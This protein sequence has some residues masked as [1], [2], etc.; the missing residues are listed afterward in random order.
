MVNVQ[1]CLYGKCTTAAKN[2]PYAYIPKLNPY[3][4]RG[5]AY[6]FQTSIVCVPCNDWDAQKACHLEEVL[7]CSRRPAELTRAQDKVDQ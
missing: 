5:L 6:R 4:W 1:L 7:R 2:E 3:V